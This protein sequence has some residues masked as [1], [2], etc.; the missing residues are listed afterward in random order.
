MQFKKGL[1]TPGYW[2]GLT[3]VED[4]TGKAW[5]G[6]L[7]QLYNG[8]LR[9]PVYGKSRKRGFHEIG[10]KGPRRYYELVS[11]RRIS[12]AMR[13]KVNPATAAVGRLS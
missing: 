4:S 6:R 5:E 9:G 11:A 7:L 1:E 3:L 2:I 12:L 8:R 10:C 13:A